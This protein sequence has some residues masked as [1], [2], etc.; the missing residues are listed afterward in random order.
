MCIMNPSL[1]KLH[2]AKGAISSLNFYV[3]QKLYNKLVDVFSRLFLLNNT[4]ENDILSLFVAGVVLSLC[5]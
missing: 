4:L 5:S 1:P 2:S 3:R